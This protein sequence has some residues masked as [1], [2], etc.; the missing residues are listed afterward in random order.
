MLGLNP[1][2]LVCVSLCE[3]CG[4]SLKH[5]NAFALC[6]GPKTPSALTSIILPHANLIAGFLVP[7]LPLG[8]SITLQVGNKVVKTNGLRDKMRLLKLHVCKLTCCVTVYSYVHGYVYTYVCVFGA[9]VHGV[10]GVCVCAGLFSIARNSRPK[11]EE[12]AIS[13]CTLH[14]LRLA[15]FYFRPAHRLLLLPFLLLLLLLSFLGRISCFC[16]CALMR[17]QPFLRCFPSSVRGSYCRLFVFVSIN[18]Y[19]YI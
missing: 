11:R 14:A 19:T 12:P 6:D 18:M 9:G 3:G 13:C 4:L 8:Q 1:A 5:G 7:P 15:P 2:F 10:Y 16:Y 17:Y